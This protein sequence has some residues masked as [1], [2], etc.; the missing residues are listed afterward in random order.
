MRFNREKKRQQICAPVNQLVLNWFETLCKSLPILVN[1]HAIVRDFRSAFSP[2][3]THASSER[4]PSWLVTVIRNIQKSIQWILLKIS[5]T[6]Q[7]PKYEIPQLP[8]A[9]SGVWLTGPPLRWVLCSVMWV[10]VQILRSG[11]QKMGHCRLWRAN[12]LYW[13]SKVH[14]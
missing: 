12:F 8:F 5:T 4:T 14:K 9:I 10:W 3:V 1:I 13:V 7:V 6:L 2:C 11:L